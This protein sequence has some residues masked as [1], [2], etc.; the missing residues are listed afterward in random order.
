MEKIWRALQK[1]ESFIGKDD[2]MCECIQILLSFFFN[3]KKD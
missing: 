3:E 2:E 1:Q